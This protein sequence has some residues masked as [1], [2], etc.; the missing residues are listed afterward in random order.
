[1]LFMTRA[2]LLTII[3]QARFCL[4]EGEP[5]SIGEARLNLIAPCNVATMLSSNLL[6]RQWGHDIE[7]NDLIASI[8][9]KWGVKDD[10]I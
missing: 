8:P 3:E 7:S 2:Q 10:V 9:K 1:M 5:T 6:K 4:V